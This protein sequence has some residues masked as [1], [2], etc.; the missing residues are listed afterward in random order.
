MPMQRIF[1][2]SSGAGWLDAVTEPLHRY[3]IS[4]SKM[5]F[6]LSQ[7]LKIPN[8][9]KIEIGAGSLFPWRIVDIIQI[10]TVSHTA[11]PA[12]IWDQT[13]MDMSTGKSTGTS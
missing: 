2:E 12:T 13:V 7:I 11:K 4:R 8:Q 1:E 9:S 3:W 5:T 6:F 10:Q